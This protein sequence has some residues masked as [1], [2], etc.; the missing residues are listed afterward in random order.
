MQ[1][2]KRQFWFEHTPDF[3][4]LNLL[5]YLLFQFPVPVKYSLYIA[6]DFFYLNK[7][8]ELKQ[9]FLHVWHDID[10]TT[11][12]NAIDE[13]HWRLCACVRAKGGHFEQLLWQYTAIWQE[14]FLF[15]S[16]VTRF[17]E[18]FWKLPQFH[19]SKFRKVVRQHTGFCWKFTWLSSSERIWKNPLIIDK[20]IAMSLVYYFLGQVY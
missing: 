5:T 6:E 4:A 19:T 1:T 13:W 17:L 2:K 10:R 8:C 18:I 12:D 7:C 11:T 16:N 14:T 20:I 3:N 15:L 9:H